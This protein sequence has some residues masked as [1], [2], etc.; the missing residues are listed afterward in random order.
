MK[1]EEAVRAKLD[2]LKDKVAKSNRS[3]PTALLV[4]IYTL[5][6]VLGENTFDEEN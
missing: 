3:S 5:E 6:W 4:Q 2:Q 1:S